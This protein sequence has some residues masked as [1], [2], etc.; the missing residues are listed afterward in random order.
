MQNQTH[1]QQADTYA[2]VTNQFKPFDWH[3]A[4]VAGP[5]GSD[6]AL[7]V[8]VLSHVRDITCGA[9]TVME[10]S[11]HFQF[12]LDEGRTPLLRPCD[13]GGLER[14][15]TLALMMLSDNAGRVGDRLNNQPTPEKAG[16][17]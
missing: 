9:A 10:L 8:D 1:A 11:L 5:H 12:D 2:P 13:L 4:G 17:P 7:L 14:L 3:N 15:A 16:Q 6:R